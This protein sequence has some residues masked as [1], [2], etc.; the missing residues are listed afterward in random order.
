MKNVQEMCA[1]KQ[2]CFQHVNRADEEGSIIT[3]RKDI[4]NDYS[5]I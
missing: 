3:S 4:N 1:Q 2:P 5:G